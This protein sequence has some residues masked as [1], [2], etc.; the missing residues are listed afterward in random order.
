M[1]INI[2]EPK[3]GQVHNLCDD[4]V[5]R[6][7]EEPDCNFLGQVGMRMMQRPNIAKYEQGEQKQEFYDRVYT[8]PIWVFRKNN[9]EH[10]E[11]FAKGD[12]SK[13]LA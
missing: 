2:T 11:L 6:M 7:T 12:L 3:V 5:D 4:F 9:T 10:P 8:E 1:C 13:W